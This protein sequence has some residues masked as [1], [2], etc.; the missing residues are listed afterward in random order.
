MKFTID[1]LYNFITRAG[2]STYAGGGAYEKIPERPGFLE[3][4]FQ[5]GDWNYRDSYTGFYRSSGS[6]VVRYKGKV[7]WVSSYCGG[8][9]TGFE[10]LSSD[11]F[12][13]LKQAMLAKPSWSFRGPDNFV[14]DQWKYSYSQKGDVVS[15]SGHEK[16][17]FKDQ[18]VFGH[19]ILGTTIQSK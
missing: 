12:D 18:V 7:V 8:M 10:K 6:E 11:T 14:Q 1:Q 19:D 13:F 3:L 4:V 5:D 2:A 16:I 17:S 9:V 15:F